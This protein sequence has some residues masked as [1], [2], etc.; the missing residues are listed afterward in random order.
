NG[1]GPTPATISRGRPGSRGSIPALA[2]AASTSPISCSACRIRSGAAR[3]ATG[4]PSTATPTTATVEVSRPITRPSAD[5]TGQLL[6]LDRGPAVADPAQH[7][8]PG[9]GARRPVD[10]DLQP[11]RGE[12]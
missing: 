5:R 10:A 6:Q 4:R 1:P 12:P 11:V 3:S 7:D 9:V 8:G 2:Q